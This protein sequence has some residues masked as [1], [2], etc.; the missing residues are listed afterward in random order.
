MKISEAWLRT[1]VDPKLSTQEIANQL[2]MLG[3]EI[4]SISQAASEFSGV[5]V[6]KVLETTKHPEA[7]KL[8]LCMVDNGQETI[9]VV[10][11]ASN[12][13][14]NLKVALATIG[15]VLPNDFKIKK[16]KLRGEVSNGMLCS[17]SELGIEEQSSGIIELPEDA[18]IGV[19]LREYLKLNDSIFDIDLTPNRADCFS[20]VGV[21]REL[22]AKNDL[23]LVHQSTPQVSTTIQD[24]LKVTIQAPEACPKY[25]GRIIKNIN[26][27]AETPIWLKE[28]LRRSGLRSLHPVVDVLNYVMLEYGQPMHAFDLQKI[29][30]AIT[31]RYAKQSEKL[32]LLNSQEIILDNDCLVIADSDKALALAGIM[33]GED[34]SVTSNTTDIF[35]ESAFFTPAKIINKARRFGLSTDASQRFERGVDPALADQALEYAASLIQQ[36]TNGVAGPVIESIYNEFIPKQAKIEFN[37]AKVAKLIG[38]DIH[39][40][41]M[42]NILKKLGMSVTI[43][44][45]TWL[46][47]PP[48]CRF[49][50]AVEVDLIEEIARV[51]GF[52]KIKSIMPTA[53]I[54]SGKICQNQSLM[55]HATQYFANRGYYETISYSFICPEIQELFYP[56]VTSQKLVNPISPEL[57][58]MRVGMWPGLVASMIH[59]IYRQQS[60]IKFIET[61][62]LFKENSGTTEISEE[63]VIAGLISGNYG[64]LNWSEQ[65]GKFDFYDLKGDI[66]ALYASFNIKNI[67]FVKTSHPAL[68]PGKAAQIIVNNKN[69]G[70]IG[71]LHPSLM[72]AFELTN[73]VILFELAL[74]S[75]LNKQP[76]IFQAISKYPQTRRDLSL[77]VDDNVTA[78]C[79]KN[80]T[81]QTVPQEYLKS[82]DIFDVYTGQGIPAGK[83][84]IA[85]SMVLQDDNSTL[86]DEK[87]NEIMDKLI[88]KLISDYKVILRNSDK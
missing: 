55:A 56:G 72:D 22:A 31:V 29:N 30:S 60:A 24:C 61:G 10:C 54:K 37:P 38:V 67:N 36:I 51:Y 71:A 23:D 34:T 11:G 35:L 74:D 15:A 14:A 48:S 85:L 65:T 19:D 25:L 86:I 5:I 83:K 69:I 81:L 88:N 28:R 32:T 8:T 33:G 52:D 4:D 40:D 17:A 78:D 63:A 2:T 26:P 9:Q 84:S 41:L 12:V 53:Q 43:L 50:I 79:L 87:I 59:N 44:E 27:N 45:D 16:S 1:W 75:L 70:I 46:V 62:V 80:I 73:E 68:H 13:R 18:P 47:T 7:D 57:A 20:V 21:A 64:D 66:E 3:L 76:T 49:D 58:V 6:A 77:L 82:F 42:L 39:S